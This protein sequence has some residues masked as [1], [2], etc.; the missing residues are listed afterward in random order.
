MVERLLVCEPALGMQPVVGVA[1]RHR[2]ITHWYQSQLVGTGGGSAQKRGLSQNAT[3]TS[4]AVT[5]S[6]LRPSPVHPNHTDNHLFLGSRK[7]KNCRFF[8]Q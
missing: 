8:F 2:R 4:L 5:Q 6:F 7:K 1:E 3:A